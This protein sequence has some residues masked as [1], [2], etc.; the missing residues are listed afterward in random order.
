VPFIANATVK[1]T[2]KWKCA[3]CVAGRKAAPPA[4]PATANDAAATADATTADNIMSD[5]VRAP[6]AAVQPTLP[7]DALPATAHDA[8]R[9]CALQPWRVLS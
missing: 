1:S 5:V 8:P 7:V 9:R 4:V 6:A 2:K 3:D